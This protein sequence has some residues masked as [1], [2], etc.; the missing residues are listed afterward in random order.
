MCL[1]VPTVQNQMRSEVVI[2][3]NI[4]R[5]QSATTHSLTG[6]TQYVSIFKTCMKSIL[7]DHK[8]CRHVHLWAISYSVLTLHWGS[9]STRVQTMILCQQTLGTRCW[10]SSTLALLTSLWMSG[11][12]SAV[13]RYSMPFAVPWA[14][15][16]R[17]CQCRIDSSSWVQT[18]ETETFTASPLSHLA[19]HAVIKM[20]QTGKGIKLWKSE[21]HLKSI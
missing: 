6:E 7:Q 11:F 19:T 9:Y 21:T 10:S 4:K 2:V 8:H 5:V 3:V 15:F 1:L 16:R 14:M 13:W 20:W 17:V 12:S 18:N